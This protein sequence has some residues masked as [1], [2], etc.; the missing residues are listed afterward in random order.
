MTRRVLRSMFIDRS[1]DNPIL[2][3]NAD[4]PWEAK[5]A[6]NPSVAVHDGKIHIVYRAVSESRDIAGANHEVSTVGHAV[7]DDGVHF[8]EREELIVPDHEWDR[9]GCEDPRVTEFEGHFF[10]FYTALSNF[11][12][13]AEGI[14]VGVAVTKDWKTFEKHPVTPFNAKAMALFPERVNGK[15]AAILAVDTDRLPVKICVALFDRIEEMWSVDYWNAW[16]ANVDQHVLRLDHSDRD[17]LEVGAAPVKTKYGWLFLYSYIFNYFTPPVTFGVQ[18]ALLDLNDPFKV[19]GKVTRPFMVPEAAYEKYGNVQNIVFPSGTLVR[20]KDLF[21]YYGGADTVSCVASLPM[22][23][24]LEHLRI[25]RDSQLVRFEG[26]PIISPKSSHP[27]EAKAAFNPAAIYDKG[28]FHILYRAMGE[29]NTSVLGYASSVDGFTISER[30]SE[31]AYVPRES[32]EK[33]L[34]PGENSGCEDPRLTMMGDMVHMCY[35]AFDGESVP[36]VAFSTIPL[37]DFLAKRWSAWSRP[38]LISK[39][40]LDDK[41]AAIF[42]EKIQGKYVFLHRLESEIWI[43]FVDDLAFDKGRFL[44]GTV[45]MGPRD[46]LWDS[47]RIG[48]SGPPIETD[49]G[50]LLLYHGISK[51][52]GHYN[53]RAALLDKKDPRKVLA[54]GYDPILEPSLPY[55]KDGI[56]PNVVFPCGAVKYNDDLFVYYGGADKVV[57][58]ATVNFKKL[59]DGLKKEE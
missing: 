46:T 47:R 11:P 51:R 53:I 34:K 49:A 36:R 29:D 50:W 12:F 38:I 31:P 37:K 24:L 32:F 48:I 57:G 28:K 14:K 35:T 45:L 40:G 15:I 5:A 41:D 39:P 43:D 9:H 4:H 22:K 8:G 52:T 26:N 10:I 13:S 17:H 3:P 18:A 56:V 54:R 42:P 33:K 19:L 16:Y 27:W 23:D 25:V 7:S 1:I 58:V 6:F 30:D 44:E 55:E 21:I 2:M 20:G 59:V